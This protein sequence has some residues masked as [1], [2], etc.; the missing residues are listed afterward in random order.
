MVEPALATLLSAAAGLAAAPRQLRQPHTALRTQGVDVGTKYLRMMGIGACLLVAVRCHDLTAQ[1][2]ANDSRAIEGFWSG[3]W[4][5]GDANGVVLQPVMAEMLIQGEHVELRGFRDVRRLAGTMRLGVT[6]KH[7]QITPTTEPGDPRTPKAIN[8]LYRISGDELT[9]F[10]SDRR[11]ITLK[12]HRV[13]ERPL[14]NANVQ[15][16][17]AAGINPAGDLLVIEFTE[18]KAGD[19]ATTYFQF[20]NRTLKT[21]DSTILLAGEKALKRITVDEA[22]GLIREPTPVV[23]TY[24]RD[25]IPL[26][27]QPHEL[28]T[29]MGSPQ[30]DGPAVCQ[31]FAR[32]LR[33]GTLIFILSSHEKFPEP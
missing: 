15:L 33:P 26:L 18:L 23:V 4:G 30:P 14:A 8:Y 3:S 32:I 19:A 24:R 1:E 29:E 10:G 2:F 27:H 20:E 11:A 7:M 13:T 16:V 22:R 12:K 21:G 25:N 28:W 5:G 17:T 31:T 6:A 9:L